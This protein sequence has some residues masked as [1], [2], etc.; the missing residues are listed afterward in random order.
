VNRRQPSDRR[1]PER[2][3]VIIWTAFFLLTMLG[4]VAIGIDVAKLM[5]TR[6]QLQNAA[7]GAALAG[8]SAINPTFGYIVQ[9]T[10]IVRATAIA[11][12]NKAF[13]DKPVAIALNAADVSF[14]TPNQVKVTVRR[15]PASG[16]SM[17]THV[18][19]VLGIKALEVSA[20][21]V[22]EA[23]TVSAI[24]EGVVPMAAIVDPDNPFLTGCNR[25]FQLKGDTPSPGNWQLLDFPECAEGPCQDVG[26][27]A[28][29]VRCLVANGYGC[30]LNVGQCVD[31]KPGVNFGPF[32]LG[33]TDR[34]NRDTD[35]REGICYEQYRGNGKRIV[36]VPMIT[37]WDPKGS[38]PVCIEGFLAF[39]IKY[40]P[41][42]GGSGQQ[43]V[44]QFLHVVVAGEGGGSGTG[45]VLYS[46]R[47]IQ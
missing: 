40:R 44:G 5:A 37:V 20:T 22:A 41:F 7:D 24:C 21:A 26:G 25:E 36:I 19:Q 28:A 35:Q 4:F 6:T 8:A 12:S 43:L 9:D 16:G 13:T 29:L 18:A 42:G 39:F 34:W 45:P 46:L 47:L 11:A 10:A 31:T 30:C 32:R 23:E 2:G 15:D 33:F 14:P 3:V 27:G 1:H 38:K 17:V